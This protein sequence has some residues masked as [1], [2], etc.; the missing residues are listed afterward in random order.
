MHRGKGRYLELWRGNGG[1]VRVT[2]SSQRLLRFF[3]F[4]RGF[5][6]VNLHVPSS[7]VRAS[8][9]TAASVASERL[10]SGVGADMGGEV[11]G[12]REVS[13][14]DATLEGLLPGVRSHVTGELVRTREASGTGFDRAAVGSFARRRLGSFRE[15]VFA[16]HLQDAAASLHGSVVVHERL[17]RQLAANE[18]VVVVV[19]EEVVR[20]GVEELVE[21]AVQFQVRGEL[22]GIA[23]EW[24]FHVHRRGGLKVRQGGQGLRFLVREGGSLLD[25]LVRLEKLLLLLELL[26]HGS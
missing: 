3:L 2:L 15:L 12:A 14:A 24:P 13:H 17:A 10:L 11:V 22:I 9:T 5:T 7:F 25:F 26:E 23:D 1:E 20:C 21:V 6:K 18:V 19:V 16:L 4:L 8:E